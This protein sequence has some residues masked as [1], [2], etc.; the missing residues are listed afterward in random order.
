MLDRTRT[1]R[2]AMVAVAGMA[3]GVFPVI[4]SLTP[5]LAWAGDD[6]DDDADD[7]SG[8]SDDGGGDE[9]TDDE[10][11]VDEDQ[12]PITAGGLYT[13]KT[14]PQGEIQ[15][16]LTMTKDITELRLGLGFDISNATAF[17]SVGLS[18]DARYGLQDNVEL[19]AG[20]SGIKNFEQW[21]IDAAFEG[22]IIYDLVDFRAGLRVAHAGTTKVSIPIGVPF[23]YAP[24]PQVA[25]TA[26]ETMFS[27]DFD[28]KPDATPNVGI[29]V[30]PVPIV[31]LILKASLIIPDFDFRADNV[32]VPASAAVQLS[33]NNK[34]DAG[35]EFRFGNLKLP[36][37][38]DIDGDGVAD[39]FYD[40]RFLLFFGRLRI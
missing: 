34:L 26:F 10:E 11:E 14:Y 3:A 20:F 9:D 29:V 40:D 5:K 25:V 27:I 30:Q 38:K 32:V 4:T 6:D 35:M 22:S 31:A 8:D 7:D 15:R 17:E 21:Q 23:R 33:P 24:K 1:L 28:G 36:E 37:G 16:P 18:G 2:L 39:K 13:L 19:R 12:P